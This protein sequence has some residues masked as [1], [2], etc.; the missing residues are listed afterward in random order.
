M[1]TLVRMY[2]LMLCLVSIV[3]R[4]VHTGNTAG[5]LHH[6]GVVDRIITGVTSHSLT[7]AGVQTM[8]CVC[9]SICGHVTSVSWY[10]VA[11]ASIMAS[12][13]V[14]MYTVDTV[15]AAV[16]CVD[17]KTGTSVLATIV[18]TTII[19]TSVTSSCHVRISTTCST[20][21][22]VSC[23]LIITTLAHVIGPALLLLLLLLV[24]HH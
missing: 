13:S 2:W 3:L 10:S 21:T 12:V 15:C 17:T 6:T 5:R 20:G 11:S 14:A 22:C 24:H 1:N 8:L 4:Y 7:V 16:R 19:L 18:L 9:A 23:H